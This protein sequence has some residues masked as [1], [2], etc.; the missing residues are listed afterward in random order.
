MVSTIKGSPVYMAPELRNYE[1]GSNVVIDYQAT[2]VWS[3]GEMVYRM[4]TKSAALF[5]PHDL[6]GYLAGPGGRGGRQV[7]ALVLDFI[8]SLRTA[9]PEHRLTSRQALDHEWLLP[10]APA[11]WPATPAS[12]SFR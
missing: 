10:L 5:T 6:S 4:L 8:Q 9:V 7:G 2:D 1:P 11:G 3:M 12:G